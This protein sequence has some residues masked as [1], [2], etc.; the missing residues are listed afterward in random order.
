MNDYVFYVIQTVV[1]DEFHY[2]FECDYFNADRKKYI[3]NYDYTHSSSLKLN[4]L[5]NCKN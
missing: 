2:L 4:S 5:R 3:Q 1:G